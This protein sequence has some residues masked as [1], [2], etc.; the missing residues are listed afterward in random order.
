VGEI[1]YLKKSTVHS[2]AQCDS[3]YKSLSYLIHMLY[4]PVFIYLLHINSIFLTECNRNG[5]NRPKIMS[6]FLAWRVHAGA[7]RYLSRFPSVC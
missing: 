2:V 4:Q 7:P 3:V 6:M 1:F 5:K